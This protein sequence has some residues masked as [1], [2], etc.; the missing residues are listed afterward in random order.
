MQH[1][2]NP[3]RRWSNVAASLN[4]PSQ[5][6]DPDSPDSQTALLLAGKGSSSDAA[7]PRCEGCG[8]EALSRVVS[9]RRGVGVARERGRT[10]PRRV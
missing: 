2:A 3:V 6:P 7:T 10:A 1:G 4:G 5:Q 9:G 8:G